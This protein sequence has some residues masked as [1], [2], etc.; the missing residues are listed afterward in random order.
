MPSSQNAESRPNGEQAQLF[1]ILLLGL[2]VAL[3]AILYYPVLSFELIWDD[4]LWTARVHAHDNSYWQWLVYAFTER[5]IDSQSFYRP[6]SIFTLYAQADSS[7]PA[8]T[9]HFGKLLTGTVE[10]LFSQH[11]VFSGSPASSQID[12]PVFPH[13]MPLLYLIRGITPKPG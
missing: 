7:N 6:I 5:S 8:Y 2:P 9:L 3:I 11:T 1:A 4:L 10:Y 13:L 12:Q